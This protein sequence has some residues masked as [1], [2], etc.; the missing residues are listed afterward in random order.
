MVEIKVNRVRTHKDD[1]QDTFRDD[2]EETLANN[3]SKQSDEA[4]KTG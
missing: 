1:L 4:A 2:E 3:K